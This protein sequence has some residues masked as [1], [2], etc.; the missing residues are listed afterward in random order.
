MAVVLTASLTLS[1]APLTIPALELP[2]HRRARVRADGDRLATWSLRAIRSD[3]L[4][5]TV[6]IRRLDEAN[7]KPPSI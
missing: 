4:R 5:L 2:R 7:P 1:R 3:P 6:Y